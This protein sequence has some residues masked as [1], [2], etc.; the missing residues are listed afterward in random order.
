M[1]KFLLTFF[2]EILQTTICISIIYNLVIFHCRLLEITIEALTVRLFICCCVLVIR[3]LLKSRIIVVTPRNQL[4]RVLVLILGITAHI[5]IA[6]NSLFI[7][8]WEPFFTGH[9]FF[10][11]FL[12]IMLYHYQ[13]NRFVTL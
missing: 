2:A 3:D 6:I 9:R 12:Q 5:H 8:L 13:K 7:I 1:K 4:L 11:I 10:G